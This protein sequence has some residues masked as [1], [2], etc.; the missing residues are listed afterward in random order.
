MPRFDVFVPRANGVMFKTVSTLLPRGAASAF[1]RAMG[2][3]KLMTEVDHSARRAYEE[4]AA[5][6]EPGLEHA[7]RA[8]SAARR[9]LSLAP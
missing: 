1:G 2:V 9:R 7:S 8:G 6:S 5:H 3:D 4:R